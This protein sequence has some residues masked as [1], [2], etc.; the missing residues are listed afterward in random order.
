[1]FSRRSFLKKVAAAVAVGIGT[2][3]GMNIP[4]ARVTQANRVLDFQ[5]F[6]FPTIRSVYPRLTA[7]DLVS[8]QPMTPRE[9]EVVSRHCLGGL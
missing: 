9:L 3:Y 7:H 8:V 2:A 4:S 6:V 1:M 5:T